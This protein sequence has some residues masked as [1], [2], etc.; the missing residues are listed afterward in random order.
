MSDCKDMLKLVSMP[1]AVVAP[2]PCNDTGTGFTQHRRNCLSGETL[3]ATGNGF[4]LPIHSVAVGTSVLSFD[5]ANQGHV[6][7]PTSA[8]LDQGTKSCVELLFSDGRS[9]KCTPDHRFLA[10]DGQWIEARL[11]I[12]GETEITAGMEYPILQ[13]PA[14]DDPW[15]LELPS[16]GYTLNMHERRDHALAFAGIL[17][18]LLTDGSFGTENG[19]LFMGHLLDIEWAQRD[20][21]LLTGANVAA[22][23]DRKITH[24][25]LPRALYLAMLHVGV[26]TA[27]RLTSMGDFPAFLLDPSCPVAVM[28]SFLGGLFGGDG[29][30]PSLAWKDNKIQRIA[31][32]RFSCSRKGS[33]QAASGQL[34][35][36]QLQ[37]LFQRVG[38][39]AG[40]LHFVSSRN[41]V[42]C[43][44][45]K[46]RVEIKRRKKSGEELSTSAAKEC[47]PQKSYSLVWNVSLND[48]LPFAE[49]IGFRYTCHKQMRLTAATAYYR[50]KATFQRQKEFLQTLGS[51]AKYPA[52]AGVMTSAKEALS[53]QE[54][55]HPEILAYHPYGGRAIHLMHDSRGMGMKPDELLRSLDALKFFSGQ[56]KGK[57]YNAATRRGEIESAAAAASFDQKVGQK[58]KS[59]SDETAEPQQLSATEQTTLDNTLG[60]EHIYAARQVDIIPLADVGYN[61]LPETTGTAVDTFELEEEEAAGEAEEEKEAANEAKEEEEAAGEAVTKDK[62]VYGVSAGAT[63]LPTF[64][65]KLI[66]RREIAG[67]LPVFDLTVPGTENFTANGLVGHNCSG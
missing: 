5:P 64:R 54:C 18:Y 2:V 42:T 35:T 51:S 13:L 57:K 52:M 14:V 41:Q 28:Q 56:R 67:T 24:L 43:I 26:G 25:N 15:Q 29:K 11:M 17:G 21:F 65:V 33:V 9:V 34:L 12:V 23:S 49:R 39:R 3:V 46:G 37:T 20:L 47:D 40:A 66:G 61:R 60:E 6:L 4:S 55:V 62:V 58:R 53:L 36:Q 48:L 16:L 7:C 44:T 32:I 63:A 59:L 50:L 31:E 30:T 22:V 27:Y 38:M 45:E 10:V 8:L 19:S 1:D